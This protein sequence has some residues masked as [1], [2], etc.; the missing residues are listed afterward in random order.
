MTIQSTLL[1]LAKRPEGCCT[2]DM[3]AIGFTRDNVNVAAGAL[4]KKG[5]LHSVRRQ[6]SAMYFTDPIACEEARLKVAQAAKDRLAERNRQKQRDRRKRRSDEGRTLTADGKARPLPK[7]KPAMP[8]T[9]HIKAYARG[10]AY[11]P[12]EPLITSKTK[13]T[14]GHSPSNPTHTTTHA[15]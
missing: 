15:E 4:F 7:Q 14:F 11:L 5:L 9:V 1:E 10:P 8:A 12:G 13:F 6:R 2:E 3:M